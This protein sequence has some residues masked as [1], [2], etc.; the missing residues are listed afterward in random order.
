MKSSTPND[1]IYAELGR[2]P[3]QLCRHISMI[4]Y[5]MRLHKID[6]CRYAKKAYK[7]PIFDDAKG[8]F[9]WVSEVTEMLKRTI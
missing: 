2:Y 8:H 7:M 4:K 1:A 9:S 3:L 5:S 6:D